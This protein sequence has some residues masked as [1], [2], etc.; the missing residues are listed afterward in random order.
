[1][2]EKYAILQQ[3]IR[4]TASAAGSAPS[5]G[6]ATGGQVPGSGD[7]DS[8]PS[9]LTPGEFVVKKSAVRAVGV[10]FLN[11]INNLQSAGRDRITAAMEKMQKFAAGGL[12]KP[13]LSFTMP[14]MMPIPVP[15]QRFADGGSVNGFGNFAELGVVRINVNDKQFPVL[16][17]RE[18]G[19]LLMQELQHQNRMKP[20][21]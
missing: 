5:V 7:S 13:E 14:R 3:E 18:V 16:T 4:R 11:F 12:V 19:V 17:K 10:N 6:M 15:V 21:Y 2:I 20:N 9:L 1:V 8:V